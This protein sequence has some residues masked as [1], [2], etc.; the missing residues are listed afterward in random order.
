M[1]FEL[2]FI[3]SLLLN[4]QSVE[5]ENMYIEIQLGIMKDNIF[6]N[7]IDEVSFRTIYTFLHRHYMLNSG[8]TIYQK[9]IF[10]NGFKNVETDKMIKKNI[11]SSTLIKSHLTKM[12]CQLM[13]IREE[14]SY[15]LENYKYAEIEANTKL[16]TITSNNLTIT[17]SFSVKWQGTNKDSLKTNLCLRN[18]SLQI[19]D[20]NNHDIEYIILNLL[21]K[22]I[23]LQGLD[24]KSSYS[25]YL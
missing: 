21:K 4:F 2:E 19:F 7:N 17:H 6:Y 1:E 22:I 23:Y 20:I 15:K 13:L 14:Q 5:S 11:I 3:K 18:L 24:S 16:N 12:V 8:W 9:Q 10:E 25:L